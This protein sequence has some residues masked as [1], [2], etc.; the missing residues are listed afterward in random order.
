MIDIV[1]YDEAFNTWVI[2]NVVVQDQASTPVPPEKFSQLANIR[3]LILNAGDH[4]YA[5]IRFDPKSL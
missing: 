5:K 1:A 3:T 2:E 4:A